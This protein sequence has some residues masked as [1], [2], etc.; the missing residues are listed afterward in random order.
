MSIPATSL[1]EWISAA[2]VAVAAK[3]AS[4]VVLLEDTPAAAEECGGGRGQASDIEM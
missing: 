2:S 4:F 3:V 1:G